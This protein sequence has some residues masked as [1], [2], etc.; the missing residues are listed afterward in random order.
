VAVL[1]PPIHGSRSHL[2]KARGSDD[3]HRRYT[4]R[5]SPRDLS[6]RVLPVN[7]TLRSSAR[8]RF[9]SP[10]I[11]K[12]SPS[13]RSVIGGFA[14]ETTAQRSSLASIYGWFHRHE[15]RRLIKPRLGV[16]ARSIV[17]NETGH[18]RVRSRSF[19]RN[20]R[21]RVTPARQSCQRL[22]SV[23]TFL[24]IIY[25]SL[26]R[27]QDTLAIYRENTLH[28][29]IA[30]YIVSSATMITTADAAAKKK[31]RGIAQVVVDAVTRVDETDVDL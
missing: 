20:E 8:R 22:A 31:R 5:R 24:S 2:V 25:C 21:K 17:R 28:S 16:S 23:D 11:Q 13:A 29:R 4:D 30:D 6:S 9:L 10:P 19:A 27:C 12:P 26:F 7:R 3:A 14:G 1:P 15:Q 18:W